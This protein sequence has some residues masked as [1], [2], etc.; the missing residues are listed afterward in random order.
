MCKRPGLP[1]IAASGDCESPKDLEPRGLPQGAADTLSKRL[2]WPLLLLSFCFR[3]WSE[4]DCTLRHGGW[5]HR[6]R[7][8]NAANEY[9]LK[10]PSESFLF[11]SW[12]PQPFYYSHGKL[13]STHLSG[14]YFEIKLDHLHKVLRTLPNTGCLS[15]MV[16]SQPCLSGSSVSQFLN[17]IVN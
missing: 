6:G 8:R 13:T 1:P 5:L 14:L 12:W 7:Q 9:G 10:P 4:W 15:D 3:L 17:R 11:L 16:V 2:K